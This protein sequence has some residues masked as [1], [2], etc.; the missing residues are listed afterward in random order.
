MSEQRSSFYESF[1]RSEASRVKY[2]A[3]CSRPWCRVCACESSQVGAGGAVAFDSWR[4]TT[5]GCDWWRPRSS[6]GVGGGYI[7][8]RRLASCFCFTDSLT[9]CWPSGQS[10]FDS[11][12]RTTVGADWWRPKSS[13]GSA[14]VYIG[15]PPRFF[16]F[17]SVLQLC[18]V[19]R[20]CVSCVVPAHS[21]DATVVFLCR[22]VLISCW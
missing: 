20:V 17:S 15:P 7:V 11:W 5:V 13:G 4:R 10:R 18:G 8:G 9:V 22:R 19:V 16:F 2:T 3:G 12:R 6:A 21:S 1:S 14:A